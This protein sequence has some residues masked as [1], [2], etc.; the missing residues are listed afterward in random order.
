MRK[1]TLV[2]FPDETRASQGFHALQELDREGRISVDAAALVERDEN[3]ALSVRQRS[4]G[5]PLGARLGAL[6]GG[7]R[8]DLLEFL[9][10]ELAPGTFAVIAEV[11]EEC[12]T[13]ID[14]RM[15]PLGGRVL[16]WTDV[17]DDALEQWTRRNGELAARKT[18]PH[19]S[20]HPAWRRRRHAHR[21]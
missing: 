11:W 18:Q 21:G 15:E 12:V 10:R 5:V 1:F 8:N 2:V 6:L 4:H 16:W 14:G 19:V 9:A 13:S 17:A 20:I 3:G 7:T